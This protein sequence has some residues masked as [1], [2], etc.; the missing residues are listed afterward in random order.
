LPRRLRRGWIWL[1]VVTGLCSLAEFATTALLFN[2][3]RV[4]TQPAA[5][6]SRA[7]LPWL[8][9]TPLV[10]VG[11][12]A[13]ALAAALT[14]AVL[15]LRAL[16]ALA[17]ASAASSAAME[18]GMFISD[19]LLWHYV[20]LPYARFRQRRVAELQR[21]VSQ[22]AR[23]VVVQV[24]RPGVQLVTDT[25]VMMAILVVMVL[26]SPGWTLAAATLVA[27]VSVMLIRAINP[28]VYEASMEV[29][30][31][32]R[33]TN[34]FVDQV[35]H[36]RREIT[37]RH[38]EA[39]VLSSYREERDMVA[40]AS[41]RRAILVELP[42]IVIEGGTMI[43]VTGLILF[44]LGLELDTPQVLAT[45]GLFAYA[46]VRLMPLV[47]RA[48]TNLANVRSG[49]PM[50]D[51]VLQDLLSARDD[52]VAGA[53]TATPSN[54]VVPELTGTVEFRHV[55]SRYEGSRRPALRDV[56]VRIEAGSFVALVGPSGGGK[57]TFV[58]LLLGLLT[59][60]AGEVLV[61]GQRLPDLSTGWQAGVGVVS[62]DPY[63]FNES[64][65]RNVVL[66]ADR[67]DERRIAEVLQQVGLW[68]FV[69][70]LPL[71][72]DTPIGERG[73]ALSGGQRQ[74]LAIAR[75]LYSDPGLLVLDEATSALDSDSEASVVRAALRRERPRTVVA[76]T[77][78]ATAIASCDQI[79][80]LEDGE[81]TAAGSYAE[82]VGRS[83]YFRR[84]V[85]KL[86]AGSAR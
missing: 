84:L 41:H 57:S 46:L 34:L 65:L 17:L 71:G 67:I 62:Q 8:S 74:R 80:V 76:V 1:I 33:W 16:L 31:R 23:V 55:S 69:Q 14:A 70:Q 79:I 75:A 13:A 39:A 22:L 47:A 48:A 30:R 40:A 12:H 49:F 10:L 11:L 86:D 68:E 24:L 19:R 21:R 77:H 7:F 3:I 4:A 32:E 36:G 82:V 56:T 61:D 78:R 29:D 37:L 72:L 20:S 35:L 18:T 25:T 9:G 53:T 26:A 6:T 85:S 52:S 27:G 15:L 64:I 5:S 83:S 28:R 50:F 2:I 45:L 54:S 51:I 38:H 58:D 44:T 42:R 63:V 60:S 66:F 43:V 59:P 73:S 81:V